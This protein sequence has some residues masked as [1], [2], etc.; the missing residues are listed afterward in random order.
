MSKGK[1]GEAQIIAALK[2][3][4]Q[5]SSGTKPVDWLLDY[6]NEAKRSVFIGDLRH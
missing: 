6:R 5:V 3:V 1:H 2:Q 4:V